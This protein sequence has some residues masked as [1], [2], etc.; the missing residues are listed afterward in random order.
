VSDFLEVGGKSHKLILI[1]LST[2]LTVPYTLWAGLIGGTF[3]TM[4]SHG[5]D[6]MMVQRYLSSRSLNQA[7]LSLILSGVVVLLQFL[8]FLLI[9]VGLYVMVHQGL[10]LVPKGTRN[11]EVFGLFIVE[12]LPH[13]LIG[14][15]IAAVLSASM[16]TLSSSLNSSAN[17]FVTDFYQPLRPRFEEGHYLR[18]SKVMTSVWGMARIA[19]ALGALY[20]DSARSVVDQVL[21]VAG[22]TTG[23]ILGLFILGSMR[24]PV[25]SETALMGLVAGFLAVFSVWLPSTW[26]RHGLAWPWYAPIGTSVTVGTAL[27]LHYL[28][29]NHGSLANGGS[30]PGLGQSG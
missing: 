29:K 9:G 1:N 3:F 11:D 30:Q 7:R 22:F 19:V 4:A 8:L 14:L 27:V 15:V 6:Q 12:R 26:G 24:R 21:A 13:G 20:L 5:A 2:S 23:M 16:A 18:V 17:A 28:R 10:L 25:A